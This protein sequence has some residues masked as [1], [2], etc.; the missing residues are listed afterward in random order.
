MVNQS[1]PLK[2]QADKKNLRKVEST[3]VEL[4]E[5]LTGLERLPG[6]PML[7]FGGGSVEDQAARLGDMRLQ[8]AQR[9]ALASR[10]GRTQGNLHLQRVVASLR[11]DDRGPTPVPPRQPAMARREGK[12]QAVQR[13]GAAHL[14]FE[15]GRRLREHEPAPVVRRSEARFATATKETDPSWAAES[16]AEAVAREVAT[17]QSVAVVPRPALAGTIARQPAPEQAGIDPAV[18]IDRQ[19]TRV[20]NGVQDYW[21]YCRTGLT[22]FTNHMKFSSEKEAESRLGEALATQ[23]AE[24]LF[25][26]AVSKLGAA[27]PFLALGKNLVKAASAEMARAKKAGGEVQIKKYING[28]LEATAKAQKAAM[29]QVNDSRDKIHAAYQTEAALSESAGQEFIDSLKESVGAY[30]KAIPDP[31]RFQQGFTEKFAQTGKLTTYISQGGRVSGQL[32]LSLRVYNEDNT[33]EVE[34]IDKEWTLATTAPEPDKIAD[35]LKDALG[36]KKPYQSELAKLVTIKVET[37]IPWAANDY[38][39]GHIYFTADPNKFEVRTNEDP[40]PLRK[41]WPHV[42][43]QVL[44]VSGIGGASK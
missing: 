14:P 23:V 3:P 24:F 9:R 13:D 32:Y 16:E 10:I 44:A 39:D 15:A 43:G 12:P 8:G 26:Q 42:R 18:D 4:A 29:A 27:G 2:V 41:A 36:G 21:T 22:K 30:I 31:A 17:G 38:T 19:I 40:T 20:E 11:Q 1:Q 33:W 34:D 35:S 5:E 37:E 25:D 7:A 28:L 6:G